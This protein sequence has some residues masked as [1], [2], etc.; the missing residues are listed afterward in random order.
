MGLLLR[1]RVFDLRFVRRSPPLLDEV[2]ELELDD[3]ELDEL[4][5]EP[6][7]DDEL[8]SDELCDENRFVLQVDV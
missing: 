6:E 7:P 8:L 1:V 3:D 4:E 5:R 2:E